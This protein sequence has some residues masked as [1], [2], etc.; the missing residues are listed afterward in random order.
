M[1]RAHEMPFGTT[2]DGDGGLTF[3]LWAPA[4]RRV[5]VRLTSDGH[6]VPMIALEGGWYAVRVTGAVPG[7]RYQ[8]VIDGES[9]VPDPAYEW[10]EN[11]RPISGAT[12]STLTRTNAK[13]SDAARYTV[14]VSNASGTATSAAA[15]VR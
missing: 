5:D 9:A 1:H 13:P 3:R 2:L 15:V 8:F 11:G 7:T 6:I 4:A 14:R 10:L 12:Q